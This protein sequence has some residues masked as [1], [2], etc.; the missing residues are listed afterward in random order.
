MIIV[1]QRLLKN[2][3]INAIALFPFILIR[4]KSGKKDRIL[5]NHEKIHLRQQ[6]EMLILPFYVWYIAEYLVHRFRLKDGY[7]AYRAISFEKEAYRNEHDASY[8][9]AR[10]FWQFIDY[11]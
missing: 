6:I 5:I 11:L 2:T 8:V 10:K 1:C 9:K 4:N 7:K 3:K